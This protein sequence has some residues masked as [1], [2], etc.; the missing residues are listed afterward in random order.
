MTPDR[1]W[2]RQ[3]RDDGVQMEREHI[4]TWLREQ[5]RTDMGVIECLDIADA[6]EAGEH[7]KGQAHD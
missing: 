5:W 7:L 3:G 1:Y 6:I 4:V 2:Y